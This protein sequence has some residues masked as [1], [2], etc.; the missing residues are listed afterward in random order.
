M[1]PLV[2]SKR[3]RVFIT[4]LASL[5][6][7]CL[8]CSTGP[9]SSPPSSTGRTPRLAL[10]LAKKD[11]LIAHQDASYDLVMTGW[12]TSEEADA[13]TA[14]APQA[15]L[16]AGLTHTWILE[17]P[18]WQT[19]LVTV[20]N[21]GDPDGPLQITDQMRLK[22]DNNGDGL[23][24]E[25]CSPPGWD[26]ISAMD[27]R[28]P[29]W[30]ELILAFY[31][32]T[33]AQPRHDGV[34]VD[35]VDAYPFCDGG[36]SENVPEPITEEEWAVSQAQLLSLIRDNVPE[37]KWVFANAGAD[38][39]PGSPFVQYINGY[40][41][42]NFLGSWGAD[43]EQGL[44]SAR[45]ALDTTR[46]PHIV[47]FAVDTED[48]GVIDWNK[49]RA[50]LAASLLLDNTYFAFDSGPADHGGVMDWWLPEYDFDLGE[51]LGPFEEQHGCYQR[52]FE[53]GTV[54]IASVSDCSVQLETE[55]VDIFSGEAGLLFE[56]PVGDAL[57]LEQRK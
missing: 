14:R 43:L 19:L 32:N 41:L 53:N 42:E 54:L 8:F 25:N 39:P 33:A 35:M 46:E 16:L 1:N 5:L 34:I 30:R 22:L 24:D 49:V 37:D 11:E 21:N 12:L 2:F 51:P 55:A 9:G 6:L 4:L 7:G 29:A 27:P 31:Q 26:Q 10:W 15:K 38:F 57:I 50:G 52:S 47:V 36:W 28:D 23:L 20:A 44:A 3:N 13:I 45:R 56:I 17:D 40:V 48:T 18:G